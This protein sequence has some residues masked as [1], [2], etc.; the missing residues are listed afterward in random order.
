MQVTRRSRLQFRLQNIAFVGLFLTVIGLLGWLSHRYAFQADWTAGNRNTLSEASQAVLEN[1][2]GPIK[3]TAFA[4]EQELLRRQIEELVSRY[5][6]YKNDLALDF[7]NPD[8]QPA[9]VRELGITV[10]GELLIEY[11]GRT[12]KVS[13]L[14]EEDLTNALQRVARGAERWVTFL[15]GHGERQAHGQ[16]N[17]DLGDWVHFLENRGFHVQPVN[18]AAN[19]TIPDN[20]SVLVIAG[21]RVDLLPGEVAL[22]E[23]YVAQGGNLLWLGDPGP[24]HGLEP[25]A[26]RLGVSFQPGVVVDPTTQ[27]VGIDQ[28]DI[29]LVVNYGS[30]PVTRGFNTLTLFPQASALKYAATDGWQSSAILH[31]VERSWSETA[32]LSGTISFDAQEDIKGPLVIGLALSRTLPVPKEGKPA[33]EET[34]QA[35]GP[36]DVSP[37]ETDNDIGAQKQRVVIIGD[38]DFLS[39]AFLN[40][41]GNLDLGLSIINWLSTDDAFIAIPVKTAPDLNLNL[42]PSIAAALSI[43]FLLLLPLGLLS[44][45]LTLWFKRR[46]R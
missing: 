13:D 5:Q 21:P 30:H 44:T 4:R 11:Q 38:G 26:E 37:A 35:E 14:S 41:G 7:V 46:K 17:H 34:T 19:P 28:P 8:T 40:N 2:P 15:E 6:R 31:T 10:D 24:L 43:G 3:I 20:T 36:T 1:I 27:L 12:E 16:A 18:L 32:D 33:A 9:R 22:I 23:N 42:S 45:G 25:L 29:T 39:N